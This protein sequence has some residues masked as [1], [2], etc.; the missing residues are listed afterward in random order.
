[1]SIAMTFLAITAQTTHQLAHLSTVGDTTYWYVTRAAAISAYALL[2]LTATLGLLRSLARTAPMRARWLLGGLD[3]LHQFS[4]LLAAAFVALHL[5]TLL[6][7]SYLRFSLVNLLFPLGEPYRPFATDLGVLALYALGIVLFSSWLRGHL[8]YR[9]WRTLHSTSF[10]A[11]ALVT[12]HG[13]LV[14][15]D[16]GTPWMRGL[17]L[18]AAGGVGALVTLRV[19]VSS[20]RHSAALAPSAR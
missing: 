2:A 18:V 3:E 10:A 11:F 14:G 6:L 17:Y 13:L 8:S 16:A 19:L 12:A 20:K 5:G 9:A 4:A 15:S 1:M 7:D